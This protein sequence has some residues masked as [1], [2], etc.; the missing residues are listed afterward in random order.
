MIL[1]RFLWEI[2]KG[3]GGGGVKPIDFVQNVV[4]FLG[5]CSTIL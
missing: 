5:C 2:E 4:T 1:L 3:G